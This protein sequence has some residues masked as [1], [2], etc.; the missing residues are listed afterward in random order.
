M[1]CFAVQRPD[2]L[3]L[4]RAQNVLGKAAKI[5]ESPQETD[6]V[7]S[8]SGGVHHALTVID[9]DED[10]LREQGKLRR[11]DLECSLFSTQ[12]G[13]QTRAG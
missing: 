5:A 10:L 4:S 7:P 13:C 1:V 8:G 11:A 6:P 3:L 9:C 12:F 2:K